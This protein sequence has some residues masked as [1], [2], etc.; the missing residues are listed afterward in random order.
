M[1][2]LNFQL[3]TPEH[4]VLEKELT[5]LTC[6]TALGD[7]TILPHHAQLVAAL[8]PGELHAKSSNEDFYI[9]I[10]GGFVEVS[11]DGKI[12]VL[13]DAAEHSFEIDLRRAEEAKKRAEKAMS[14]SA[15]SG[16]EYA[17][18]AAALERSLSRLKVARKR[19]RQKS[20]NRRK[21]F[22]Q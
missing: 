3:V 20:N 4:A 12:V 10:T 13:A 7:I 21:Y 17:T 6:P 14:E 2:T 15:L 18:V 1:P 22:K 19:S 16:E 8:V 11:K 9:N 5:S